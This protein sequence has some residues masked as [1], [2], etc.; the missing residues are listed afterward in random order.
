MVQVNVNSS[1]IE[2]SL[3]V[4]KRKLQREGVF[5]IFRLK[6]FFETPGAKKKR[7]AEESRRR[8]L[9]AMSEENRSMSGPSKDTKKKPRK[10]Y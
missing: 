5:K 1:N 8:R 4:L 2:Q 10:A 3:R 7:K 6:R 9:K